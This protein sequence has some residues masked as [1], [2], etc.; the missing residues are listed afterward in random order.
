MN[1]DFAVEQLEREPLKQPHLARYRRVAGYK[2]ARHS[3]A[4]ARSVGGIREKKIRLIRRKETNDAS[5]RRV[6]TKRSQRRRRH[7]RRERRIRRIRK[8]VLVGGT[9][10]RFPAIQGCTRCAHIARKISNDC[11]RRDR[12]V[13][14]DDEP[15][16][17]IA[18]H[19]TVLITT[20]TTTTILPTKIACCRRAAPAAGAAARP[21]VAPLC[22][23][24]T[25]IVGRS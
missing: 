13:G 25:G 20:T 23:I 7:T 15:R 24:A 11:W 6:A 1:E 10:A 14:D 19:A 16:R 17:T 2:A 21:C 22:S 4:D 18:T 8:A 3:I 9:S 12:Y 5:E